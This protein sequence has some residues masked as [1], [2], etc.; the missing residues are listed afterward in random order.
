MGKKR[1][2]YG[3]L[4]W[5]CGSMRPN[6]KFSGS[7]H[8]RHLC[9]DC[10]RLGT[11]EL[12]YR[13]ELRNLERCVSWEGIIGRKRR[14][15]FDKFLDHPDPRIRQYAEELAAR[16]GES[17]AMLRFLEYGVEFEGE[18]DCS[19]PERASAGASAED[20][21]SRRKTGGPHDDIP[22]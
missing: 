4:C 20:M 21:C 8:A 19:E 9:K 2:R 3:H 11:S 16:D 13:Q 15:A 5:C 7:G 18:D 12:Q 22:F 10:S 17:R 1:N 6:E 14:K